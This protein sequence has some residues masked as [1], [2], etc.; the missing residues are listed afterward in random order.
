VNKLCYDAG[1]QALDATPQ[2]SYATLTAVSLLPAVLA[3]LGYWL[4]F[5]RR[6]R[7]LD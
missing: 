4:A 7:R 3:W 6:A 2:P 1:K 5:T